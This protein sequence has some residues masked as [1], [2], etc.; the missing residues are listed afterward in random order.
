MRQAV[1]DDGNGHFVICWDFTV[2][3]AHNH[4]TNISTED[5]LKLEQSVH[6]DHDKIRLE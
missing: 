2:G 5:R 4:F 3:Y 1:L 6:H